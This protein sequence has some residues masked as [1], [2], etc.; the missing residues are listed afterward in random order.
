[1]S[2][3]LELLTQNEEIG[4]NAGGKKGRKRRDADSEARQIVEKNSFP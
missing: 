3:V 4:E 2:Q 1:M